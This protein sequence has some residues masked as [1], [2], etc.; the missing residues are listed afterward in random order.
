MNAWGGFFFAAGEFYTAFLVYMQDPYMVDLNWRWL[1][2]LG[3]I[4]AFAFLVVGFLFL[5][6]SPS[7]LLVSGRTAEAQATLEDMRNANHALDVHIDLLEPTVA[8]RRLSG[9]IKGNLGII[10]GRHMLYTTMVIC[11]SV[12]TLN[13]IFYGGLYAFPQALPELKLHVSP[14]VNL[15]MG[16]LVELPGC[17]LGVYIGNRYSQKTC[18]LF[19]LL[20]VLTS[21]LTFSVA[22][23]RIMDAPK[24]ERSLEILLQCGLIGNKVFTAVGFLVVYVYTAEIYPT[25]ARTTGGAVCFAFGRFGAILA[26]SIYEKLAFV[27]GSHAF[28]SFTAFLCAVN[29]IMVLFLPFETQ[30]LVLQDHP[31]EQQPISTLGSKLPSTIK[32][33]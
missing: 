10:L 31:E 19:Y 17:L 24:L 21:T 4:P 25:V 12:F 9:S 5:Q 23:M 22:S 7:F 1:I 26:P 30:G 13:F 18:M 11:M 16:A 33:P 2:G 15:M 3:T 29:A 6:E 8:Q 28:F 20:M 27:S 14:S 32:M